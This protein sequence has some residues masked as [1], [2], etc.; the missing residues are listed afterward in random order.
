M[1]I[2]DAPKEPGHYWYKEDK[3]QPEVMR[4]G[5][6]GLFRT[7]DEAGVALALSEL[8]G[9]WWDQSILEPDKVPRMLGELRPGGSYV[10]RVEA[11]VTPPLQAQLNAVLQTLS[12][13][14]GAKFVLLGLGMDIVE[15]ATAAQREPPEGYTRC[16]NA[17]PTV[18]HS[19]HLLASVDNGD[20]F[21]LVPGCGHVEPAN[22]LRM[23]VL[24]V[25][26]SAER[27][28]AA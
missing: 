8:H 26:V 3:S 7:A 13:Q 14:T 25:V 23:D 18:P 15:P 19:V 2:K 4:L 17:E 10:L 24:R 28:G 21:C 11:H 1:W 12:E 9:E 6:D 16:K 22:A 20:L 5:A 27:G